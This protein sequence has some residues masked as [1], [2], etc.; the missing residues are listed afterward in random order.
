MMI[1]CPSFAS[2][3]LTA[4]AEQ[5]IALENVSNDGRACRVPFFSAISQCHLG[6]KNSMVKKADC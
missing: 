5:K 6:R 2:E 1:S 4:I 3:T